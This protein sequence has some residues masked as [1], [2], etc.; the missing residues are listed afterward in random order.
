MISLQFTQCRGDQGLTLRSGVT[1]QPFVEHAGAMLLCRG[2]NGQQLTAIGLFTSVLI[3][4]AAEI[5]AFANQ[6]QP[7]QRIV[8][9]GGDRAACTLL[10][11]VNV[12]A[13]IGDRG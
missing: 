9:A 2:E 3:R 8:S 4:G 11:G 12:S 6:L 13:E 10:P 1:C 5:D 7:V